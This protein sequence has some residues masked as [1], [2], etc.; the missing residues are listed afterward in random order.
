[1]LNQLTV[2]RII[3]VYLV[4]GVVG[5]FFLYLAYLILRRD[6]KRLNVIFSG[7]YIT[8]ALAVILNFIYAPLTN[9]T[10]VLWLNFFTNFMFAYAGIFLVVFNLILLKSE[11]IIDSKKQIAILVGYG[12]ALLSVMFFLFLEEPGVKLNADTGWRPVYTLPYYIYFMAILILGAILPSLYL[13]WRIYTEFED[14]LLKRK[15]RFFLLGLVIIDIFMIG[16]FTMNY[17]NVDAVRDSWAIVSLITIFSG[18]ALIYYGV[19]KQL[20]Q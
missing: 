16:T 4:Q 6:K 11:K 9:E 5:I 14:D 15:W 1:M 10:I 13:S 20:E 17:I 7:F 2:S 12:A 8:G 18:P 3:Q 19:G